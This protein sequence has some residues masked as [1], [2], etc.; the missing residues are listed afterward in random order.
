MRTQ[1]VVDRA[2]FH[3]MAK[4]DAVKEDLRIKAEK[5]KEYEKKLRFKGD[6]DKLN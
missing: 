4:E 5:Q 2:N 3:V 1:A 6:L